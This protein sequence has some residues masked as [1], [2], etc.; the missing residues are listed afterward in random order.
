MAWVAAMFELDCGKVLSRQLSFY[1]RLSRGMTNGVDGSVQLF[2]SL[3]ADVHDHLERGGLRFLRISRLHYISMLK[4][5]EAKSTNWP[6]I[7]SMTAAGTAV[8]S[9]IRQT[10]ISVM[11]RITFLLISGLLCQL[12]HSAPIYD[13][14]KLTGRP[15]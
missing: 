6:I 3:V 10:R 1:Q 9:S 8:A 11:C 15:R 13:I 12:V 5:T 4:H 14:V 2:G 7:Q